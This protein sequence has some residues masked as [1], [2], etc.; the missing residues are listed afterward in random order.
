MGMS[1]SNEEA[2]LTDEELDEELLEIALEQV[3][4]KTMTPETP[5]EKNAIRN[6]L[7]FA[8]RIIQK[9][10]SLGWKS[11]AE[12][13]GIFREIEDGFIWGQVPYHDIGSGTMKEWTMHCISDEDWQSLKAKEVKE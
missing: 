6:Y 11:P 10:L 3:C 5:Y 9:L 13:E 4:P 2:M 8:H 7:V 1:N 12:F